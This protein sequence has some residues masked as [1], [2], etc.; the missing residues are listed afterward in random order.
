MNS[1]F[2]FPG[3]GSQ[4]VGMG[5]SFYDNSKK[6]KELLDNASDFCKIDFKNLLFKENENL[7]KSEFTQMAIV[8]NS[9]MAYEVLKEQVEIEAKYSLGHSLG[10]F[11]ALAT[12]DAFSFL[13]VIA[14]VNKRGQFMQEDCSKIEAGMM[15]ILGLEDKVVEELCQKA[16]SEKKNIFAANYNCDGQIVVAGLKPDLASYE[17]EFKNAGAKRAMLLN[18]SVASHCPLLK[19]ASLKLTKELE[20]ILKESFKSVVSNVNAKVYND[21]NQALTLLSEQLIKPVLYKQSIKA[22]DEEVEFYIEFGASVL[23][24]LN[25]KIT[26]KETYTL[27]K[28]EDIDEILKVVK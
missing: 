16:L 15:V 28:I 21:K 7:N 3:Q 25:K 1:A 20:P 6:A 2:I 8:L 26:Q 23:K 19:N 22:I 11:S 24:G 13:D 14:L 10:E 18:M 12:Q 17:S 4:S 5:L 9:L 27:S